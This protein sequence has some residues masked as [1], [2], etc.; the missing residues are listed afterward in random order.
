MIEHSVPFFLVEM[1]ESNRILVG[2]E[3]GILGIISADSISGD[4][5]DTQL[6]DKSLERIEENNKT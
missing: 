5:G 4:G 1:K 3:D 6:V 2:D